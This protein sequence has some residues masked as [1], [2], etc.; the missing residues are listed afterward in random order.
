M[1][2]WVA[3]V[4]V[5]GHDGQGREYRAPYSLTS[6][7]LTNVDVVDLLRMKLRMLIRYRPWRANRPQRVA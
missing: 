5:R 2:G 1:Y 6:A 3:V 7:G 4:G